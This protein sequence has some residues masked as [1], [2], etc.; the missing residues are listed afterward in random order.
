MLCLLFTLSLFWVFFPS[1]LMHPLHIIPLGR[2]STCPFFSSVRRNPWVNLAVYLVLCCTFGWKP[3]LSYPYFPYLHSLRVVG[4]STTNPFPLTIWLQLQVKGNMIISFTLFIKVAWD[5]L[6]MN[7]L[8]FPPHKS[9][10]WYHGQYFQGFT[11][12]SVDWCFK[13]T[14]I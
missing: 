13:S 9:L 5:I 8:S 10:S 1:F 4:C 6:H 2:F 12:Q 14:I 3:L 11:P 7:P